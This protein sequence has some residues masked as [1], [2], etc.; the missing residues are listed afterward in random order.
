MN[1]E[2]DQDIEE[3]KKEHEKEEGEQREKLEEE[4]E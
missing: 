1:V 4:E 2:T 3:L